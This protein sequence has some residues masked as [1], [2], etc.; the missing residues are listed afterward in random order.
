MESK[1]G[2]G[3]PLIS[4]DKTVVY[5]HPACHRA[6][7]SGRCLLTLA[8]SLHWKVSSWEGKEA[9]CSS[10]KHESVFTLKFIEEKNVRHDG[11]CL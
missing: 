8:C 2:A 7:S 6:L 5:I 4:E 3:G 9:L 11:T 1:A 10:Q